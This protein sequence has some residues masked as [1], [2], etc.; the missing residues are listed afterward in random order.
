[1]LTAGDEFGRS[2]KGNNNAYAQDNAIT[3]LDWA[4]RDQALERHASAL[5]ILRRTVPALSDTHFLTGQPA[6]ASG[7]P[8]VA[9][10]TETGMQK[11][12]TLGATC[13]C[14][15]LKRPL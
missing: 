10:L 15:R 9:W 13:R 4:G 8:D 14:V 3:W 7:I 1:M 12:K 5:G 11:A 6:D 2:Q